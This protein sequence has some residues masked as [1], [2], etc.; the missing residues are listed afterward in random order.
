MPRGSKLASLTLTDEQQNQLQGIAQSAT[1][2]YALVVR[3][4][5]ILASAEGLTNAV[6]AKRV[7]VTPHTVGKWR[8]RFREAG[9]EGLHDEIRPGR[10]RTYDDDK[11]AAVIN[12]VRRSPRSAMKTV[13][14]GVLG[15]RCTQI[16]AETSPVE[17]VRLAVRLAVPRENR[18]TEKKI[19]EISG[20]RRA[21]SRMSP[22]ARCGSGSRPPR[23]RRDGRPG[24]PLRRCGADP[25]RVGLERRGEAARAGGDQL[26]RGSRRRPSPSTERSRG[27]RPRPASA[28]ARP[29][30]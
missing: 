9:I 23:S 30:R 13:V 27:A 14:I 18:Q 1:L 4:R 22:P 7:G 10:P 17:Q 8:R 5:I 20:R 24:R 2:P 16:R 25:Q 11:V 6:V 26:P 3:A 21:G 28:G 12:P 15:C 19:A 29:T